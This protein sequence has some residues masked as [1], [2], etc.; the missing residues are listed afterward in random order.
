MEIKHHISKE[1]TG[2][3]RTQKENQ[4]ISKHKWQWKHGNSKPIGCSKSNSKR[5]VYT[6]T[7]LSEETS[8]KNQIDN[9]IIHLK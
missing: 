9:L 2:C 5:E 6:S 3:W 8:L 1:Q 7:I 4:K